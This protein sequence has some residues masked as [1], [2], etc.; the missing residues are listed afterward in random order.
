MLKPALEA[1]QSQMKITWNKR[2]NDIVYHHREYGLAETQRLR[3]VFL[4]QA[5]KGE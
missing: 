3:F 5:R 1:L 4:P 2:A